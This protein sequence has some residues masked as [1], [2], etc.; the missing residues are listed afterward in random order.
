MQALELLF[1]LD[2]LVLDGFKYLSLLNE[3]TH[4]FFGQVG[5]FLHAFGG[6]ELSQ[7]FQN[8]FTGVPSGSQIS[9]ALF[10]DY[11]FLE[12]TL[13]RLFAALGILV[14]KHIDDL[15]LRFKRGV[16]GSNE[17]GSEPEDGIRVT[18][19]EV[20][21]FLRLLAAE[22][23]HFGVEGHNSIFHQ[24][25][26]LRGRLALLSDAVGLTRAHI[27]GGPVIGLSL[28]LDALTTDGNLF[29]LVF[30]VAV[31]LLTEIVLAH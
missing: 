9:F 30:V 13:D 1:N 3:G 27:D 29:E 7:L 20:I 25:V 15:L 10:F 11:D 2:L 8:L 5:K 4:A 23:Q 6:V 28:L 31:I 18:L 17:L 24:R 22:R 21:D 12:N 16:A 14:V 26:N 19:G